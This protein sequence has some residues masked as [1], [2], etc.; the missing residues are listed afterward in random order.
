MDDNDLLAAVREDFTGVRMGTPAET[1]LADGAA[2][3]HRRHRRLAY[4]SGVAA[5]A[6]VAAIGGVALTSGGVA[7]TS[8][9]HDAHLAAYTVQQEQNGTIDVTIHD[10]QNLAGLE[11]TLKAD[12]VPAEVISDNHYPAAC[13]DRAAMDKDMANV[14]T[15]GPKVPDGYAFVVHPASIPSGTKLLLDVT[16][17]FTTTRDGV[18]TT[19]GGVGDRLWGFG[20]TNLKEGAAVS[21][22]GVS[23]GMGLVFTSGNC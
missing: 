15:I 20:A 2:L 16:H 21:G 12:G 17:N 19:V 8:G 4:G 14:I 9:T 6:V 22:T 1:I 10:L 23:A 11:Q 18:T 7:S 3:R 5:V 13:V